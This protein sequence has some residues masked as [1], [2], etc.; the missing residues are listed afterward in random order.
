[1]APTSSTTHLSSRSRIQPWIQAARPAA[2]PMI[3]IPLFMGQALAFHAHKQFSTTL[4]LYTLLFGVLYQVFLLYLNDYADEAIDKTNSQ[5]WLSGGSR[6]LPEGKLGP[7]DLLTG[8]KIAF[9]LM[10]ALTLCLAAFA[11]RPWMPIALTMA[12]ALCWTYNMRPL[13]L[14]YRGHGEVL[15][16]LGCG[17]VLVLIGFYMQH[18]SLSQFSWRSLIPLYL[19]FHAGNIIT[20]LPD[21]LSD[22]AGDK[23]THPVRHGQRHARTT[24][25]FLLA[26]AH[27]G[28]IISSP[29]ISPAAL[30][31]IVAPSA[32]ILVFIIS[33]GTMRKADVA[34][35]SFCKKF[36]TWASASQ[37]WL[38][39]AWI[40]ALLIAG[41]S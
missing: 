35:F 7:G 12:A 37:A 21:Y 1:M 22:R 8:A 11:Y 41:S 4:F 26:V 6:V 40:G 2:H 33:S 31:I 38:L 16:G 3:F 10:L 19:I 28:V 29:G 13:Q 5:Y 24:A 14:S 15:Q 27:L 32:L 23:R 17:V 30:A 39:C 20:A 18:G 36:V 9:I 25:L 34:E